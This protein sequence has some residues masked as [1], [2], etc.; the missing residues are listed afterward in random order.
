MYAFIHFGMRINTKPISFSIQYL[1]LI[2]SV[3]ALCCTTSRY[4]K[5]LLR[6]E[7]KLSRL[8]KPLVTLPVVCRNLHYVCDTCIAYCRRM[9]I[10]NQGANIFQAEVERQT[11]YKMQQNIWKIVHDIAFLHSKLEAY[12]SLWKSFPVHMRT[13]L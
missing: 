9:R 10:N 13:S 5:R 7:F 3:E 11:D 1:L 6:C 8:I 4:V 12:F 2:N